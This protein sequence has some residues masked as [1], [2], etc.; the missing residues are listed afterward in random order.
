[1]VN[2]KELQV[3]ITETQKQILGV[4]DGRVVE[5]EPAKVIFRG[6]GRGKEAP[7]QVS[8]QLREFQRKEVERKATE[9]IATERKAEQ[10]RQTEAVRREESRQ[11]TIAGQVETRGVISEFKPEEFD[12]SKRLRIS[13]REAVGTFFRETGRDIGAIA[14]GIFLGRDI[15]GLKDPFS[16]FEFVGPQKGEQVIVSPLETRRI[17]ISDRPP[18]K[19]LF[20][21]E[22][23]QQIS[24]GV[25]FGLIGLTPQ[26]QAAGISTGIQREVV[27]EFRGR[28]ETGELT[29]EVATIQ[30]QERFEKQF[31]ERL[32]TIQQ[33]RGDDL[34]IRSGERGA[35]FAKTAGLIGGAIGLSAISPT[36][37]A[38]LGGSLIAGAGQLSF[39]AGTEFGFSGK[40]LKQSLGTLGQAGLFAAGGTSLISGVLGPGGTI[41]RQITQLRLEELRQTP[42]KFEGV[43]LAKSPTGDVLVSL[44]GGRATGFASQDI[45]LLSPIFRD[46]PKSTLTQ[47]EFFSLVGGKGV[48]KTRVVSFGLQGIV[49][50]EQVILRGKDIFSFTGT[51]ATGLEGRFIPR[52]IQVQ[53]GGGLSAKLTPL[54][55]G[56]DITAAAGKVKLIRG[57]KITSSPFGGIGRKTDDFF[58]V[59]SGKTIKFRAE[60]TPTQ[61]KKTLIV[62]PESRAEISILKDFFTVSKKDLVI[63]FRGLD[64]GR[65]GL[66]GVP[67]AAQQVRTQD[68]LGGVAGLQRVATI[69]APAVDIGQVGL[70]GVGAGAL[71]PLKNLPT[72]VG[73]AGGQ[74][75]FQPSRGAFGVRGILV[76]PEEAGRLEAI[77]DLRTP[78]GAFPGITG[79]AVGR[80]DAGIISRGRVSVT[81]TGATLKPISLGFEKGFFETRLKPSVLGVRVAGG[82]RGGL[83][84]GVAIS[85]PVALSTRQFQPQLQIQKQLLVQKSEQVFRTPFFP[86]PSFAPVSG[87]RGGFTPGPGIFGLPGLVSELPERRRITGGR[88]RPPRRIAPSL[89]GKFVFDFG[90]ITGALPKPS[91]RFGVSPR[92][93]RTIPKDF[94]GGGSSLDLSF[95]FGGLRT[96]RTKR[97]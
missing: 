86:T 92:Q 32:T 24:A 17:T 9:R 94:F 23:E 20:Q 41:P 85:Q 84:L 64:F 75:L 34:T 90:D 82:Q 13:G 46:I 51:G 15:E 61:L 21:L 95:G 49:P 52:D 33:I 10:I 19:T 30:A 87:F 76:R 60:L 53:F 50:E 18:D 91:K 80:L 28:V 55:L 42:I 43:E 89:T 83:G 68:I 1:M 40:E 4:V 2:D 7:E 48:A 29:P 59:I 88:I 57:D 58:D 54:T 47:K 26:A 93:I 56:D 45:E 73:G 37:A 3:E 70:P 31:G 12:P 25:P 22:A 97:R 35:A 6:R 66:R 71:T 77:G 5:V 62:R 81:P 96:R 39:K 72:I 79:R 38:G 27:Q 63:D 36:F 65:P 74:S 8:T 67:S 11:R 44:K 78:I 16:I 69:T 14:G